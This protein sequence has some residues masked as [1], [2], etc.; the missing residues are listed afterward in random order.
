MYKYDLHTI[1]M[2]VTF[3]DQ[4]C[5]KRLVD[6]GT[7]RSVPWNYRWKSL[8]KITKNQLWK[9]LG[10]IFLPQNFH[11]KT[12]FKKRS[13]KIPTHRTHTLSG[14]IGW[15][16][17]TF[18]HSERFTWPNCQFTWPNCRFWF[19]SGKAPWCVVRPAPVAAPKHLL[20]NLETLTFGIEAGKRC[21]WQTSWDSC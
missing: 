6:G 5:L 3:R 12:F 11:W 18:P 15:K 8:G 4:G 19:S 10:E 9:F 2:S 7:Q 20:L 21:C 1:I 13:T 14:D 17:R 16:R